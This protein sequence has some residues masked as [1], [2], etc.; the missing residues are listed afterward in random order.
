MDSQI[1][2]VPNTH[3]STENVSFLRLLSRLHP[4]DFTLEGEDNTAL[5]GLAV[6][7]AALQR[8][9]TDSIPL[10]REH[11]AAFLW[12]GGIAVVERRGRDGTWDWDGRGEVGKEGEGEDIG[13]PARRVH[14]ESNK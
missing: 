4:A 9:R 2:A 14:R 8:W 5:L 6:L 12:P 11:D 3:S 13:T 10:E 1:C 7:L